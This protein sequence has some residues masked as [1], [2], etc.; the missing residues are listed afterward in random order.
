MAEPS[1][2]PEPIVMDEPVLELVHLDNGLIDFIPFGSFKPNEPLLLQR[3]KTVL[4]PIPMDVV[5]AYQNISFLNT[6]NA[7][8]T[9]GKVQTPIPPDIL[10]PPVF[11]PISGFI[12]IKSLGVALP[13]SM[14]LTTEIASFIDEK[15]IIDIS[16]SA[17]FT[18]VR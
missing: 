2:L 13:P 10:N 15:E 14:N 16:T 18:Y 4:N 7:F 8:E 9:F 17:T 1:P 3:N 6:I 5:N 12:E 11:S